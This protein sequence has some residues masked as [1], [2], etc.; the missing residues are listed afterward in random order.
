M[1]L[2]APDLQPEFYADVPLK[3]SVAWAVD[4]TATVV[5]TAAGVLATFFVSLFF[6]PILYSLVSVAY[7]TVMLARYG[8]TLGMMLVAL[9][10]RHLDGR[11]PDAPTAL[12]Y[13]AFHAGLWLFF[14]AQILSMGLI[15]L[16]PQRQGL[17]DL[18][19]GTTMLHRMAVD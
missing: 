14:P 15:M 17:H 8:A 5:L 10:W 9:E 19:L 18:V 4:M 12:V 2:P 3:R 11:A 7:R 13:S 1:A 16:T 6:L